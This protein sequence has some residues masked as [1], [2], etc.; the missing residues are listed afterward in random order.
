M[1]KHIAPS[2][3]LFAL[4]LVLSIVAWAPPTCAEL[5]DA[6]LNGDGFYDSSTGLY[7][8]D[9]AV[10][11]DADRAGTDAMVTHS[12]VWSWATSA[13]IDALVGAA[14]ESGSD[15]ETVMGTR[16]STV[17]GG[18]PRWLGFH[19]GTDPDGWLIQS[20][21]DP[22]F[23]TL[24]LSGSQGSAASLGAGAWL[25]STIDP[26]GAA[27]VLE[28]HGGTGQYF[29]DLGTDL[30]WCDPSTFHGM[31]RAEIES[32]LTANPDWRWATSAEV[33]GLAGK[34]S[35]DGTAL[36]QVLGERL[37]TV[38]GGGPRWVGLHADPAAPDGILLQADIGPD[39]YLMR[40]C[41]TQGAA[42]SL[43]CGAWIVRSSDPMPV[44]QETWD[45][46]KSLYR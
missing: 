32:W 42:E 26:L 21:D 23:T 20:T 39:F 37:T 31:S 8:Y 43:G 3:F 44:T 7:W 11:Y 16:W 33:Y 15:L 10:F 40:S 4:V 1:P 27:A 45:G 34:S 25:V 14:A 2:S 12:S 35:T 17:T 28:D 41:G 5:S 29:H 22:D 24:T 9:P 13:Q 6:G 30:Y 36:D 19:A 46:V 38:T 18:G